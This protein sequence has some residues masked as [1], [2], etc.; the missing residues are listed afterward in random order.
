M[1]TEVKELLQ[2]TSVGCLSCAV[3]LQYLE[4]EVC[5][6]CW[7]CVLYRTHGEESV[8][9]TNTVLYCIILYYAVLCCI[10]LYYTVLSCIMLY[11]CDHTVKGM[12]ASNTLCYHGNH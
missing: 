12:Y 8:L 7:Q 4:C 1:L 6:A 5:S 9:G 2:L 3:L 11:Y 10:M